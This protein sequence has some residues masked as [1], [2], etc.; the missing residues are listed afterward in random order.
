MKKSIFIRE[1]NEIIY[2]VISGAYAL[3]NFNEACTALATEII[4]DD[5]EVDTVFER[6]DFGDYVKL[7]VMHEYTIDS[8]HHSF[9]IRLYLPVDHVLVQE[10]YSTFLHTR[11]HLNKRQE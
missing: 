11:V 10:S 5:V 3:Q 4:Q 9:H 8:V 2:E 1:E 6:E 7:F